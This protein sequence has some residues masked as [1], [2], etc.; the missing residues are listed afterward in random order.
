MVDPTDPDIVSNALADFADWSV[1]RGG[2]ALIGVREGPEG[3]IWWGQVYA[4]ASGDALR[5]DREAPDPV[6]LLLALR[7]VVVRVS[8]DLETWQ[9]QR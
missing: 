6:T 1:R 8:A 9:K 4:R 3:R 2:K 5:I 7:D